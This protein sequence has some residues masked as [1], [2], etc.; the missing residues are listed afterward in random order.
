[1]LGR[2]FGASYWKNPSHGVA[3]HVTARGPTLIGL[4]EIAAAEL[5]VGLRSG[6]TSCVLSS[7]GGQIWLVVAIGIRID[8]VF[9]PMKNPRTYVKMSKTTFLTLPGLDFLNM[10]NQTAHSE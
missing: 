1:V 6:G 7:Q 9:R 3:L 8:G 2:R 4:E 5:W 10:N